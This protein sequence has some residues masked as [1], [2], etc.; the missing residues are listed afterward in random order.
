VVRYITNDP[1]IM[2]S[3]YVDDLQLSCRGPDLR[4]IG[5]KL[6]QCLDNLQSWSNTNGFKFSPAKTK[7]VHFT[8]I[9]GLHN[10]PDLRMTQ[11]ILPYVENIKFLGLTWDTKLTWKSHINQ[12]KFNCSKL[13]GLLRSV[14]TQEW[15]ADQTSCLKLFRSLIR[16]KL[17]YGVQVYGSASATSLQSLDTITTEALRIATGAFKSTPTDTLYILANEMP[18]DI[19]REYLSLRYYYK[20]RSSLDNP[21]Y[22]HIVALG[23][24][25]LFVNKRIPLPFSMRVQNAIEQYGLRKQLVKPKF[26]YTLLGIDTPTWT[27]PELKINLN[28]SEHPKLITSDVAYRSLFRDECRHRYADYSIIYTDGSK[29]MHGVGAAAVSSERELSM[30][31]PTEASI[32]SAEIEAINLAVNLIRE[33]NDGKFLVASDSISVLQSLKSSQ[34]INPTLRKVKH[35]VHE[36]E[37]TGKTIEFMWVPGH[38]GIT[39]NE[40]AD[41]AAKVASHRPEQHVSICYTDFHPIIFT[42]CVDKWKPR[43]EDKHQK[44]FEIKSTPGAW[45]NSCRLSRRD[46]VVMNRLRSGHCRATHGYLMDNSVQ[47]AAPICEVCEDATLTV[48]HVLIDCPALRAQRGAAGLFIGRPL[49]TMANLLGEDVCPKR[50]LQFLV[51]INFRNMI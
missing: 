1:S 18:P 33:N 40:R 4:V 8:T 21:A 49:L 5:T 35:N 9:P 37:Q 13:L 17:D 50:L 36:M 51:D 22:N 11:N 29:D 10:P 44:I 3:L 47:P 24:R 25:T 16:S 26:S 2:E 30:S 20:T 32:F 34:C 42:A 28:L 45:R 48:K 14:T 23:L 15:G 19:R 38:V 7:V 31:M 41:Q 6:Q 39:G 27:L 46:E 43:W 12:L